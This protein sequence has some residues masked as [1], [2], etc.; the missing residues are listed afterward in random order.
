MACLFLNGQSCDFYHV[1]METY[2]NP[3]SREIS[4][5]LPE[6]FQN[7]GKIEIF[8]YIGQKVYTSSYSSDGDDKITIDLEQL[9]AGFYLIRLSN[10][11]SMLTRSIIKSAK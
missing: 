9:N 2:P 1:K 3:F 10:K 6:E 4:I 5:F 8:N 11:N 7:R